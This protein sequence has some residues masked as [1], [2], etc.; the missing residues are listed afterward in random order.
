[1]GG[2]KPR[3]SIAEGSLGGG[4]ALNALG[5]RGIIGLPLDSTEGA[6]LNCKLSR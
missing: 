1:V 6:F 2:A 4:G 5:A 3:T